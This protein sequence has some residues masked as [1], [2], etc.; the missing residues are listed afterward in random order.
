MWLL[1]KKNQTGLSITCENCL[2]IVNVN[3]FTPQERNLTAKPILNYR[4]K[5]LRE[6]FVREKLL[7][8]VSEMIQQVN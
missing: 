6:Y 1:T 8:L 2:E 4:S 7:Y 5:T 3:S